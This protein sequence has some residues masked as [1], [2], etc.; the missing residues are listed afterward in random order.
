MNPQRRV[1]VIF[2]KNRNVIDINGSL[3]IVSM[4]K[5]KVGNAPPPNLR[6][7]RSKIG[8]LS[9][10]AH[11]PGGGNVK[12][13][14][15]KLEFNVESRIAAKNENYTPGGGEKKVNFKIFSTC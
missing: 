1:S 14:S 2:T 8:S 10:A 6:E 3:S 9:N 5:I 13:E 15:K 4:N 12:I 11:R 7:V